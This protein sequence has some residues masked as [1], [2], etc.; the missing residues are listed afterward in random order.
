[1]K[2]IISQ[3]NLK[4]ENKPT[5]NYNKHYLLISYKMTHI[6]NKIITDNNKIEI[7]KRKKKLMNT[8][9]THKQ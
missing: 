6:D 5:S 9:F 1:M 7:G 2:N 8:H 3:A 4:Q